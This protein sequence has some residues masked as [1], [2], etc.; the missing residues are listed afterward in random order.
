MKNKSLVGV[1]LILVLLGFSDVITATHSDTEPIFSIRIIDF[2]SP[3]TLGGFMEFSYETRGVSGVNDTA[4]ISFWIQKDGETISSGTD[5][6][7]LAD[8]EST[9]T[10]DIFIPSGFESGVYELLIEVDYEGHDAHASRTIEINV[11]GGLA[12]VNSGF[13][14]TNIIIIIMLIMLAALNIYIVYHFEMKKIKKILEEEENFI[15]RHK[16]SFLTVI[17]FIILGALIY[18]LD[19]TGFLPQIPIYYYYLVLAV[20]LLVVLSLVRTKKH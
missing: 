10:A 9:R 20:L 6:I 13:G 3:V 1:L 11:R 17:F 15:K 14:K 5:T 19:L 16:V 18:Y 4:L 12:T 2:Q 8:K 7:Y